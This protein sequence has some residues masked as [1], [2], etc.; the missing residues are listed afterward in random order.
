M[1]I[2]EIIF[3]VSNERQTPGRFPTRLIFAHNF[4]DYLSLVGELKAVCDEVIDLSAFTK[5][6]VLPRFK[7]FKNELFQS[8]PARSLP[9]H[10]TGQPLR[11]P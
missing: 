10:P 8:S 2:A 4:T 11:H 6:D 3:K 9:W 5:G 1:N 7:D